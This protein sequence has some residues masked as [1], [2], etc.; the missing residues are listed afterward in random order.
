MRFRPSVI[1]LFHIYYILS[2]YVAHIL[3][4][5]KPFDLYMYNILTYSLT[6]HTH[7]TLIQ[8]TKDMVTMNILAM[9]PLVYW[10]A[11]NPIRIGFYWESIDKNSISS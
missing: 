2:Y 9:S 7:S 6:Q 1:C 3:A 11:T 5:P 4:P 10:I 8:T